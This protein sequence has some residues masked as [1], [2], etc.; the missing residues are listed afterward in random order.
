MTATKPPCIHRGDRVGVL[1]CQ[2][3]ALY[4]CDLLGKFCSAK[5]PFDKMVMGIIQGVDGHV[6]LTDDNYQP[7]EAC[8]SMTPPAEQ[9]VISQASD[10]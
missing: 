6:W 7:C 1:E 2:C 3:G 9:P 5:N 8:T 4:Q 10:G